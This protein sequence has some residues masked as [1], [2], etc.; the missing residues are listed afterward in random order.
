MQLIT[1]ISKSKSSIQCPNPEC[2]VEARVLHQSF[3][4]GPQNIDNKKFNP[5]QA[6]D[7]DM[8]VTVGRAAHAS[9]LASRAS[10]LA[11][12]LVGSC[13]SLLAKYRE[14]CNFC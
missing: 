13:A 14:I 7:L 11:R 5:L 8:S 3:E 2:K 10:Y 9:W 6:G 1:T 4:R 12:G